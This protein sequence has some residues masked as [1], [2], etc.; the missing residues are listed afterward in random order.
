MLS[1]KIRNA[2]LITVLF[3][4]GTGIIVTACQ[5]A[6]QTENQ[7]QIQQLFNGKNLDG[8][9][10]FLATKGV[11]NDPDSIFT[12][13]DAQIRI[14]GT[15]NGY[16]CTKNEYE[17]FKLT[18]EFRYGDISSLPT[19]KKPNSGILYFFPADSVDRI[20]P[21]AVECQ[22]MTASVGDYVLMGPEMMI[23]GVQGN[24]QNRVF[25][26]SQDAEK[27]LGEWNIVQ[28]IAVGDSS[29]HIVNGVTVNNGSHCSISK[30]K[31]LIQS[32]GAELFIRKVELEPLLLQK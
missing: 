8:F 31:I 20:W 14:R 19:N 18:I 22:L 17:N 28:V 15:E 26:K 30:G 10:K 25:A 1:I 2:I 27:P 4:T 24:A 23:N 3:F 11:D 5:K 32:E 9:Y 12:I 7:P 21:H 16:I 29:T 6:T 13:K